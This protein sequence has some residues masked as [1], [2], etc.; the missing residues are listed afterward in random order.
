MIIDREYALHCAKLAGQTEC[1]FNTPFKLFKITKSPTSSHF[2]YTPGTFIITYTT[3][4]GIGTANFYEYTAEFL[5]Y[6]TVTIVLLLQ[7][8]FL[9]TNLKETTDL[10]AGELYQEVKLESL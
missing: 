5:Q 3:F 2:R 6:T 7:A 10:E 1:L 8:G 4:V 9:G